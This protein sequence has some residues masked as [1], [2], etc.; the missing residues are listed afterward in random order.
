MVVYNLYLVLNNEL[1][2]IYDKNTKKVEY[3]GSSN[4][5]P[6]RYMNRIVHYLSI[7]HIQGTKEYYQLIII[8]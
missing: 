1:V 8:D 3:E 5:I 6:I 7:E 2:K 4:A